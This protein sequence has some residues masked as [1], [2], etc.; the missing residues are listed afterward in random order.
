M[1]EPIK[2]KAFCRRPFES[3][4]IGA[5]GAARVCCWTDGY[6]IGNV[7]KQSLME[8]WNGPKVK[9][10]RETIFDG[11]YRFCDKNICP[12][13]AEG[14][15]L[16][17]VIIDEDRLKQDLTA[18]M[19]EDVH[20]AL[21]DQKRELT[22]RPKTIALCYDQTCNLSC[23]TCRTGI[24]NENLRKGEFQAI[25][26]SLK[27]FSDRLIFSGSGD[28]FFSAH[29]LDLMFNSTD[30]DL[31]AVR[32]IN[33]M[34]NGLLLTPKIWERVSE[35][36]KKKAVILDISIDAACE[37]TYLIN[38][39]GGNWKTLLE[40]LE[41][42]AACK[43]FSRSTFSFV[44]QNNNFREMKDFVR[45]ANRYGAKVSFRKMGNWGTFSQAEFLERNIF[46]KAHPNHQ[47]YSELIKDDFFKE[48]HIEMPAQE[49]ESF[50]EEPRVL[51]GL[52]Y[53]FFSQG[54]YARSITAN[55]GINFFGFNA[56][57]LE[58]DFLEFDKGYFSKKV[59]AT[60]AGHMGF[61]FF[62][63]KPYD[64]SEY[65][66]LHLNIK[67]SDSV[68]NELNV[69][70]IDPNREVRIKARD[71][72]FA[73]DGKFRAFKIPLLAFANKGIDLRN[74]KASFG[75]VIDG[76]KQGKSFFLN[77]VNFT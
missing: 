26:E 72:G 66:V 13:F 16:N 41:F 73:A 30:A 64:L 34:T 63:D 46:T 4:E 62:H 40:N 47:E 36:F 37:A 71:F 61:G 1:N 69:F 5:N 51:D 70:L 23:P 67:S 76:V 22:F 49:N 75:L 39:R 17:E 60:A 19:S 29:F 3:V 35:A 43:D 54:T 18:V 44:V 21:V 53:N 48:T 6:I 10:F 74:L 31:S 32:E 38:R 27:P 25:A 45:F 33:I 68:M 7:A 59:I 8:I 77:D 11:S 55:N 52:G 65:S 20:G 15:K 2:K 24:L 57:E 56:P 50:A 58:T 28:P 42:I 12:H 9:A 14:N